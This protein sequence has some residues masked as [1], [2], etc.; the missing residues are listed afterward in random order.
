MLGGGWRVLAIQIDAMGMDGCMGMD[1]G[2]MDGCS[3]DGRVFG[4]GWMV[5]G[6]IDGC[7]GNEWVLL[8]WLLGIWMG[9]MGMDGCCGNGCWNM[10]G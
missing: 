7:Y 9:S 3:G 2:D 10:A 1:V 6:D 4:G 5:V 8:E